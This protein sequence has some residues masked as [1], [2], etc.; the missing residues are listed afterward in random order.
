MA[1]FPAPLQ[2]RIPA[3]RYFAGTQSQT[4]VFAAFIL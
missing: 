2:G 3:F 4:W 1:G